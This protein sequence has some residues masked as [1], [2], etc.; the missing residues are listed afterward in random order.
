MILFLKVLKILIFD[1]NLLFFQPCANLNWKSFKL[2]LQKAIKLNFLTI[3]PLKGGKWKWRYCHLVNVYASLY[4]SSWWDFNFFFHSHFLFSSV[5]TV[6][7][8]K[9][10]CMPKLI[11]CRRL[12]ISVH[13]IFAFLPHYGKQTQKM[14]FGYSC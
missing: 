8:S 10:K 11:Y 1:K 9:L 2:I 6:H 5:T 3:A 12:L 4:L 13:P 7:F 14:N